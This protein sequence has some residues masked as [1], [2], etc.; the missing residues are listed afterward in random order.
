MAE[1]SERAPTADEASCVAA[2]RR[3]AF[4]RRDGVRT[5]HRN[6]G[7]APLEDA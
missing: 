3:K 2:A 6:C 7:V 4:M 5:P 1:S